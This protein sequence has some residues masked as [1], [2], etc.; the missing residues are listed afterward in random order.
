ME[1]R[2]LIG[3][4]GLP[5]SMDR[6][7]DLNMK[8]RTQNDLESFGTIETQVSPTCAEENREVEDDQIH[9]SL[10]K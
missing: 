7:A 9:D 3:S 5:L 10:V 4:H 8:F 6:I 1:A 2:G